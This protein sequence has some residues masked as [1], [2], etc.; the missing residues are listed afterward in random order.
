[1][2]KFAELAEFEQ[3]LDQGYRTL[4]FRFM[5]LSG[6]DYVLTNLAGEFAVAARS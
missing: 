4:P 2:A 3:P 6:D 1:M 5:Q